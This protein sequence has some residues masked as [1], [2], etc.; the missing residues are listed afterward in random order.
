MACYTREQIEA[1]IHNKGY[2]WFD[3]GDYNLNIIGVRNTT[4]G[5]KV[6]NR[7]DD[8]ITLTY[9][10]KKTWYF[11]CYPA[12]TEPGN[13][14]MMNLINKQG[15]AILVPGQ[16]FKTHKIGLH[17]GKYEALCQQKVLSVY[18]DK[19]KDLV[20]DTD[21]GQIDKGIFGIN[22][23]RATERPNAISA[24]VDKWSAGCQVIASNSDWEHF[25]T[26]CK[27]AADTWG[28]SFTYTLIESTDIK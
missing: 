22:I 27:K 19:N 24:L 4:T 6:T 14:W 10:I 9:K 1:A 21:T 5:K 25:I 8:C 3:V 13:H 11:H 17:R 18:R 15:S 23:H 7:F 20:Y 2:K 28:N 26:I 16:Y 12:T